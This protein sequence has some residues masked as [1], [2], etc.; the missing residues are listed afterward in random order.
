MLPSGPPEVMAL[1]NMKLM[2]MVEMIKK[3]RVVRRLVQIS[4]R[5]MW[6][7]WWMRPA[8]SRL[9]DSYSDSG[10]EAMEA[11]YMTM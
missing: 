4:G 5:V 8:P 3:V 11:I 7:N 9:A 6:K 2:L 1:T 10:M